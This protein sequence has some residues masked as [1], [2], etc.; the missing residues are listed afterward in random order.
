MSPDGSR[1]AMS[2]SA[3]SGLKGVDSLVCCAASKNLLI[4]NRSET[5]VF[6]MAT[7]ADVLLSFVWRRPCHTNHRGSLMQDG[8]SDLPTFRLKSQDQALI[9]KHVDHAW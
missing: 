2:I 6:V 8:Q 3:R 4:S 1:V 5:Y 9:T 7:G